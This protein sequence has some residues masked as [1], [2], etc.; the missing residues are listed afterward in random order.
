MG[1]LFYTLLGSWVLMKEIS[2]I[3]V[4]GYLTVSV[5][6]DLEPS[7]IWPLQICLAVCFFYVG[8][9]IFFNRV[10]KG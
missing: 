4:L 7:L 9:D 2:L 3:Y 10:D 5:F 8:R 6:F 1:S